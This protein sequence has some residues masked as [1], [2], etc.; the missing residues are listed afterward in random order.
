METRLSTKYIFPL[1][2]RFREI[3]QR[4]G[5]HEQ[6]REEVLPSVHNW[7]LVVAAGRPRKS[8]P[9]P[10]RGQES[11][12]RRRQLPVRQHVRPLPQAARLLVGRDP[13]RALA[14]RHQR[15]RIPSQLT[16]IPYP[17]N[18]KLAQ[19]RGTI[20]PHFSPPPTFQTPNLFSSRFSF[21]FFSTF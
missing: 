9:P 18:S 2:S 11:R 8:A 12:Q 21:Y 5:R 6:R 14:C 20:R 7:L 17:S 19:P 1:Q 10:H 16:F 3:R 15:K 4:S 13:P